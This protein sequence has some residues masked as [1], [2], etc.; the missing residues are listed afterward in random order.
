MGQEGQL[1]E[2]GQEVEQLGPGLLVL[3]QVVGVELSKALNMQ[4]FKGSTV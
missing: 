2:G 3:T 4:V 1:V